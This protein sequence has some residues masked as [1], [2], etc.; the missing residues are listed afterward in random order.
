MSLTY[1]F[2]LL[3]IQRDYNIIK[4]NVSVYD[5]APMLK[6]Y[7]DVASKHN[8]SQIALLNAKFNLN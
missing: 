2:L 7:C 4:P 3:R 6:N 5:I 1:K 8:L